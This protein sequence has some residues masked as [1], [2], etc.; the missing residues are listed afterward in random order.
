MNRELR[1][2]NLKRLTEESAPYS[3]KELTYKSNT[4]KL[5]VFEIPVEYLIFNQYNG[6]I[7]TYVKTHQR[8]FGPIDASTAEGEEIIVKFLWNSKINRNKETLKDIQK[9]GQLEY[10]IVTRVGVV[11]D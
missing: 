7:G 3:H 6:R 10:D 1:E 9:N 8:Q 2:Q 4:R 5:P 11:V